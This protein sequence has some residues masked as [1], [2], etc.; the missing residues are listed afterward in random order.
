MDKKAMT[1]NP[2]NICIP[3]DQTCGHYRFIPVPLCHQETEYTCGVACV[4]SILGCYGMDYRQDQLAQILQSRPILGT[5][6]ENII[7]FM[8]LLG[9]QAFFAD[10]LRL[11]D[12]KS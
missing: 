10:K 7:R 1:T 6:Y 2:E 9:F 8:Q 3:E 11:D 12:L 4:Q 5:D